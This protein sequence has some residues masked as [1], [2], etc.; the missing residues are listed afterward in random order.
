MLLTSPLA[1]CHRCTTLDHVLR[2]DAFAQTLPV[3]PL[4]KCILIAIIGVARQR[5]KG[6]QIDPTTGKPVKKRPKGVP[7]KVP[8]PP[9]AAATTAAVCPARLPPP[10]LR[11]PGSRFELPLQYSST[12][13]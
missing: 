13:S 6:N 1:I 5:L 10:L 4:V 8:P 12:G 11:M 2:R 3:C 9:R 7:E